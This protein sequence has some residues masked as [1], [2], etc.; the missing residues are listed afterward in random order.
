VPNYKGPEAMQRWRAKE[1]NAEKWKEYCR[2]RARKRREAVL[3]YYGHKCVC[4]GETR[5]EFLAIDHTNGGGEAH[6]KKV[7]Q[8]SLMVDFIIKNNFPDTFRLLCH[9]CNQALGYYG[10]C[11]HG[12]L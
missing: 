4:C 3:A 1:G 10:Y 12:T 11:P 7:G 6:R 9:N 2:Q 8:G 5:Y